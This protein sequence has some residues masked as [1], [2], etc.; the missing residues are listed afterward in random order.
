VVKREGEK[1]RELRDEPGGLPRRGATRVQMTMRASFA[2]LRLQAM[3]KP[4]IIRMLR[5]VAAEVI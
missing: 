1:I 3:R 4:L 5:M 2:R